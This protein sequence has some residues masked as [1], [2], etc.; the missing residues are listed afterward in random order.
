MF[1]H[2]TWESFRKEGYVGV[3]LAWEGTKLARLGNKFASFVSRNSHLIVRIV[4]EKSQVLFCQNI[5]PQKE[6]FPVQHENH[7]EEEQYISWHVPGKRRRQNWLGSDINQIFCLLKRYDFFHST[8][9][10]LRRGHLPGMR[11]R[12]QNWWGWEI[13][14]FFL[15]T[16]V[17]LHFTPVSKS[18]SR[19]VGRSFGLA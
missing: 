16:L 4:M 6:V 19:W 9:E 5:W 18:V 8:W 1:L 13:I 12:R 2:S 17:A 10:S 7:L 11:R 3:C 14:S 15:A